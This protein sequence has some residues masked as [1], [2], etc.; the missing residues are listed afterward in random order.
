MMSFELVIDLLGIGVIFWAIGRIC[1]HLALLDLDNG[2]I[3]WKSR[4]F[5][6]LTWVFYFLGFFSSL[7]IGGI[8]AICH[9]RLY[10]NH[11]MDLRKMKSFV[12]YNIKKREEFDKFCSEHG[13]GPGD[14]M[15]PL[16]IPFSW[17]TLY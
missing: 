10:H 8:D 7:I 17:Y 16:D 12:P 4:V 11:L 2:C 6:I 15:A 9:K 14:S 5:Y 13:I 1:F 3:T